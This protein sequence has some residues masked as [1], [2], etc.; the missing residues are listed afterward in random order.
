MSGRSEQLGAKQTVS[1]PPR[2][3]GKQRRRSSAEASRQRAMTETSRE[4]ATQRPAAAQTAQGALWATAEAG[5]RSDQRLQSGSSQWERR[6]IAT[7]QRAA[8]G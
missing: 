6:F 4:E 2:R 5:R 3:R 7:N 8:G 1:A